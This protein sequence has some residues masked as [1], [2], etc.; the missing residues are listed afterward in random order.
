M[1]EVLEKQVQE[2]IQHVEADDEGKQ[3]PKCKKKR[4]PT[5]DPVKR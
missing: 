2:R 4:L 1:R 5:P 3:C